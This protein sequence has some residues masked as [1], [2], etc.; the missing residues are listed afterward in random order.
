[1]CELARASF[2]LEFSKWPKLVNLVG[3]L[4]I[5]VYNWLYKYYNKLALQPNVLKWSPPSKFPNGRIICTQLGFRSFSISKMNISLQLSSWVRDSVV[6]SEYFP[7]GVFSF[8]QYK[9]HFICYIY[10]RY[11]YTDLSHFRASN[12][13]LH[14]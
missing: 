11:I 4:L 1:M 14:V 2:D 10:S 13:Y 3:G 8:F 6:R 5:S 12:Q 9:F 7:I